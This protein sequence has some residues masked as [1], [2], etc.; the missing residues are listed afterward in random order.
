[1]M[2]YFS[3]NV[4]DQYPH[5]STDHANICRT[6]SKEQ[7]ST[8][9]K[10]PWG[11]K[12]RTHVLWTMTVPKSSAILRSSRPR[13]IEGTGKE[14]KEQ[15]LCKLC[16][17]GLKE[18]GILQGS[19]GNQNKDPCCSKF[20]TYVVPIRSVVCTSSFLMGRHHLRSRESSNARFGGCCRL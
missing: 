12:F 11:L 19:P 10:N 17:Q 1:M 2:S 14:Q 8:L 15:L 9:I 18:S 13:D 5:P 16:F 6:H 4:T 3:G 7:E 20:Y